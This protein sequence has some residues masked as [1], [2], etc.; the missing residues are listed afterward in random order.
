MQIQQV[1]STAEEI[2]VYKDGESEIYKSG[3]PQ[4]EQ[5]SA[6]WDAMLEGSLAMPAFGVSLDEYT[7]K[8]MKK[9]VW[10]EFCFASQ[11]TVDEMPFEKLLVEVKPEY[12]GFNVNRH[13]CGSGYAGRCYY[14][15]LHGKTME[16]MYNFL[17]K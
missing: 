16:E 11:Q 9:G 5:I 8:A 14:I 10:L 4:F 13:N 6:R 3:S 7:S 2:A 12:G 17:V 15:D 1:F